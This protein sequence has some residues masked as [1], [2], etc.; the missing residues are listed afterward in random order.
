MLG[1]DDPD[2]AVDIGLVTQFQKVRLQHLRPLGQGWYSESVLFGGPET[3][4]FQFEGD[5]EAMKLGGGAAPRV[6]TVERWPGS[7]FEI[8]LDVEAG[9]VS[10]LY[11]VAGFGESEE[12]PPVLMP[13]Y[14]ESPGH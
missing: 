10:Y 9:Q 8:G 5:G 13:L 6:S 1:S 14:A 7:R 12:G 3:Q 2:A 11:D 4:S